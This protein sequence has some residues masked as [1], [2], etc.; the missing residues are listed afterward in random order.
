ME[1]GRMSFSIERY[2]EESKKL[3]T[4][5][6]VMAAEGP[7]DQDAVRRCLFLLS[8][9]KVPAEVATVSATE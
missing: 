4:D 3:D 7:I 8:I 9:L 5:G 6:R 2:K 1:G